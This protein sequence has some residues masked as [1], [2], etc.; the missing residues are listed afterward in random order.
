MHA[1]D[2]LISLIMSSIF[3]LLYT[4]PRTPSWDIID[5]HANNEETTELSCKH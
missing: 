4:Q 3:T 2:V 1:D 5:R